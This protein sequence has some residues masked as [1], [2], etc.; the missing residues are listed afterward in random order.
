MTGMS[1]TGAPTRKVAYQRTDRI[2][3]ATSIAFSRSMI[4]SQPPERI[5]PRMLYGYI[6]GAVETGTAH[7]DARN[8]YADYSLVP[9]TLVDVAG[10]SQMRTLLGRTYDAPFGLP[11]IGGAAVAAFEGDIEMARA[12]ASANIPGCLSAAS[13]TGSRTSAGRDRT[14]GFRAICRAIKTVSMPWSI[15]LRQRATTRSSSRWMYRC[16]QSR[17]QCPQ[18]LFDAVCADAAPHVR[19]RHASALAHRNARPY[20]LEARMMYFENIDATRGPP[21][22]SKSLARNTADRDRLAWPHIAAIRAR[23]TGKLVI[24]GILTAKMHVLHVNTV[25]TQ[26]SC[27]TMAAANSIMRSRP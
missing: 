9:S 11:P 20:V 1:A 12:C 3:R 18:W 4:L 14:R 22:F 17:E 19:L 15:G 10:R 25:R 27:Q 7:A 6:S 23:W 21:I 5:L 26:W 13:L 2:V 16:W 8:A 24:K